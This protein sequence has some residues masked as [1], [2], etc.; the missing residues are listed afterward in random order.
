[1]PRSAK[2]K[3]RCTVCGKP[4]PTTADGNTSRFGRLVY[5]TFSEPRCSDR[6]ACEPVV[7]VETQ[8]RIAALAELVLDAKAS[9]EQ[10]SK[11]E[12]R[13]WEE[14]FA[15]AQAATFAEGARMIRQ[16]GQFLRRLGVSADIVDLLLET[17][18]GF[19]AKK[20]AAD[21]AVR[22]IRR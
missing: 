18:L 15:T 16:R 9:K 17:A 6:C 14:G 2:L 5:G 12:T 4:C 8:R 13:T 1:M 19:D 10:A 7:D 21:E 3:I 11:S 20:M 22:S